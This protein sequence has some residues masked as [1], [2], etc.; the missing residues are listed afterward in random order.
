VTKTAGFTLI[1]MLV[2]LVLLTAIV[3]L[4]SS[5]YGIFS[6]RWDGQLGKFDQT[7]QN[8]RDEM[9]V[10]DVLDSLTS[11]ATYDQSE[12][13][14]LYFEG[15]RNGFVSV[16]TKSIF[17]EKIPAVVRF[18]AVQRADLT[19]DI[20]YEEWPMKDDVLR[21][22]YQ[23]FNFAQ[24]I[25]LFESVTS[26]NFEYYGWGSV[27]ER[28]GFSDDRNPMPATWLS[29]LNSLEAR[30]LPERI[31]LSFYNNGEYK[32]IN[33]IIAAQRSN[34]L[35]RFCCLGPRQ[36]NGLGGPIKSTPNCTC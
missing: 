18:S 31:R 30:L 34:L 35:T 26:P 21:S 28:E 13:P 27:I 2:S 22:T 4:G 1:E 15:N 16:S 29:S 12:T 7:L 25:K 8:V 14:V 3:L 19:F 10:Y 24:P 36:R 33:T 20:T 11:Y 6:Q 9:L 23:N 32:E 5:S 17:S